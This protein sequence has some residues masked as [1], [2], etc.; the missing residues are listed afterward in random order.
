MKNKMKIIALASLFN[1]S[2]ASDA[3][4][5]S[6]TNQGQALILPY[7]TTENDNES[8]IKVINHSDS[9]KAVR[10][11]FREGFNGQNVL[12]FNTYLAPHDQF[13]TTLKPVISTMPGYTGQDSAAAF[14]TD[15]SCTPFLSPQVEFAPWAFT[16][17]VGP[18]N[19]ARARQGFVQIVELGT[20]EGSLANAANPNDG[21]PTDCSQLENAFINGGVWE[22]DPN[23]FIGP[24][25][26]G[27]S[28]EMSITNPFE[29][30]VSKYAAI[31]LDGFYEPGGFNHINPGIT[32]DLLANTD[33]NK[34]ILNSAFLENQW[35]Q[36]F[37]VVSAAFTQSMLSATLG[38][39]NETTEY[40]FTYPTK[41]NHVNVA[42]MEEPFTQSF[43][44]NGACE[45]IEKYSVD[46]TGNHIGSSIEQIQ[47]CQSVNVIGVNTAIPNA[48]VLV[49][50]YDSVVSDDGT[51]GVINFDF[52]DFNSNEGV[53]ASDPNILYL[54]TGL[55]VI[56]IK[57]TQTE[58]NSNVSQSMIPMVG[59]QD[60]MQ[61]TI[62][63]SS[64][65]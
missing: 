42:S 16:N 27:L 55:P 20:V 1:F 3:V 49:D 12:S 34:L 4:S 50:N 15:D 45:S 36:A 38:A 29:D 63:A 2:G 26:G 25:V 53:L 18:E 14:T 37:Q 11:E 57:M 39:A 35:N 6:T 8:N 58:L 54:Y 48:P 17:D 61:E 28:A 40:V 43:G 30:T 22:N 7:Y 44:A 59:Q 10:I 46:G 62:S 65:E 13:S 9:V 32:A 21:T 24:A 5:I 56:G 23:D 31:A 60:I 51:S 64:F 52:S 41:Y 19:M 33:T 47:M